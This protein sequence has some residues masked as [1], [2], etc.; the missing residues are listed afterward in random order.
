[1]FAAEKPKKFFD[2]RRNKMIASFTLAAGL[3]LLYMF[4][5]AGAVEV[6]TAKAT[7]GSIAVTVDEIGYIQADEEYDVLAPVNGYIGR[8]EAE[9]GQKVKQ[10]QT[11]MLLDS[12]E[13]DSL[14]E[15][16]SAQAN[17]VAASL[18]E[19][20]N[21]RE[22]A[23][24]ELAD[25]ERKVAQR[26]ALLTA[27]AIS[28]QEF[29]EAKLA[30][31]RLRSRTYST[32]EIIGDLERQLTALRRQQQSAD[33]RVNQFVVRSPADGAV[34]Y[35]VPKAGEY[36]AQGA[37]VAKIGKSGRTRV[38][39]DVLSDNMG[40]VALGQKVT[41]GSPVLAAPVT[42]T[43]SDIYPQA[44]E[45]VSA[46]GVIQRRVR[47]IADLTEWGNLRSG[48]EVKVSIT[49]RFKDDALL[50]PREALVMNPQG[51]YEVWIVS[52]GRA[53]CRKVTVGLKNR[54]QVEILEGLQ[55]QDTVITARRGEITERT[56]VRISDARN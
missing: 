22:I 12:P 37:V 15:N 7:R 44:F 20:R 17:R 33:R 47:V 28:Q 29:D 35:L 56:R 55:P 5:F 52:A 13:T 30:L 31:D 53:E 8:L 4:F 16:T 10:N 23:L 54:V 36:V 46:L 45:K 14:L 40:Y 3:W 1:M 48:Y 43:I 39:V 9:R 19:A 26:K 27:G 41:V 21:N 49:T 38:N 18:N 6:S 11:L 32:G 2:G 51:Q 34:I 25:A 24:Y 42:G 50:I